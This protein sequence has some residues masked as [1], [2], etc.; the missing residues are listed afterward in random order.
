MSR[1]RLPEICLSG[2]PTLTRHTSLT[3]SA[4][5]VD[6]VFLV[7][8]TMNLTELIRQP[9]LHFLLIGAAIFALF[10]A[11]DD[12]PTVSSTKEIIITSELA[13]QLAGRFASVKRRPPTARELAGLVDDFIKEEVLVREA[14]ALSLDTNDAVIRRRL[15]QKMEF[16]TSSAV[17][18]L[19]PTDEQLATYFKANSKRYTSALRN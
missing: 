12:S 2:G 1:H 9:L 18:A 15:R 11:L 5:L 3:N 16:L 19:K 6:L 4:I 14:T 10:A 17:A 7:I 13:E 8:S